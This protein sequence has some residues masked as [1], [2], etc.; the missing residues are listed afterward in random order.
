MSSSASALLVVT[1]LAA[2]ASAAPGDRGALREQLARDP[3]Q[4]RAL[5]KLAELDER[6]RPSAALEALEEAARQSSMLGPAPGAADRARLGRL[7]LRRGRARLVRGA[8]SAL[9]DLDRAAAAGAMPSPGE[10]VAATIAAALGELRSVDRRRHEPALAA[11]AALAARGQGPAALRGARAG[12]TVLERGLLG[13]WLWRMGAR[14]A[15][16]D[17]LARWWRAGGRGPAPVLETYLVAHA[18]W[19]PRWRG[20]GA[21]APTEALV[22]PRRCAAGPAP[23]CTPRQVLAAGWDLTW[24]ERDL[25]RHPPVPTADPAE[26]AAWAELVA[27]AYLA[28]ELEPWREVLAARIDLPA[29]RVP[30][31]WAELP[32]AARPLLARLA[33]APAEAAAEQVLAGAPGSAAALLERTLAGAVASCA[34]PGCR[35]LRSATFEG[36]EPEDGIAGP[37]LVSGALGRAVRALAGGDER[38][39]RELTKLAAGASRDLE[40][41][42]RRLAERV[43]RADD[44]ALAHAQAGAFFE[45][46]GDPASARQSWQRATALSPEPRFLLGEARAL[47]QAGDVAAALVAATRAAAAAGD[48]APVLTA[49]GRALL[50]QGAALGAL[51]LAKQA[52]ELA[53]ADTAPAAWELAS[54]AATALA[55]PEVLAALEGLRAHLAWAPRRAALEDADPRAAALDPSDPRLALAVAADEPAPRAL[56]RLWRTSRFA[57]RSVEVRAAILARAAPDDPRAVRAAAELVELA[58]D[59]T[60]AA[61]AVRAL[62]ASRR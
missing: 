15:G 39:E 52:L 31:R 41:A 44:A 18:W 6:E 11:L 19:A 53:S 7:L 13:A 50:A 4:V 49:C 32:R 22:G 47:A 20:D 43:A 17:Q 30:E 28:G 23:G 38:D 27:R 25:L 8:S 60:L 55:R 48:P 35:R 21:P 61:P 36:T 12:A 10:R 57:V 59:P 33:G 40:R 46:Q 16:H 62:A 29:L 45:L 34:A 54:E 58:S 1:V 56:E 9:E 5:L 24:P 26:A 51:E 42:R 37:E 3:G 2:C 14:R